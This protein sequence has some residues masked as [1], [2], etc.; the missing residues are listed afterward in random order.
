MYDNQRQTHMA[1]I[2]GILDA[3]GCFM[4][5][6]FNRKRFS[7]TYLPCIKIAMIEKEAISFVC[8]DLK[9]GKYHVD[10][11]R[12]DRPN[13]KPI[14]HWYMRSKK[15]IIPFLKEVIPFLRVKKDR[16]QHL[17]NYCLTIVDCACPTMG[18]KKYEL[19]YREEAY[20]KMRE[21]NGNKVAATT[22]SQNLERGSDSLDL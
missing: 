17:L 9:F 8:D 14:F 19:N 5:S 7:P 22:E 4:I 20:R 15:E 10:G 16:A 1:Y 11:V 18:L 21:F 6:K 3:D 12:K 13:S 2:A